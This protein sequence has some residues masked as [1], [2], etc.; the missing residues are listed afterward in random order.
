MLTIAE[1][2]AR[3]HPSGVPYWLSNNSLKTCT[4]ESNKKKE[5]T[6]LMTKTKQ[7]MNDKGE[8]AGRYPATN[9]RRIL[10]VTGAT[11]LAT[12][13]KKGPRGKGW[14]CSRGQ[15]GKAAPNDSLKTLTAESNK[16]KEGNG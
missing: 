15:Q 3:S 14:S 6:G 5:E 8:R 11:Y 2:P 13:R 1:R 12:E 7:N 4:T 10:A 9:S 16:K